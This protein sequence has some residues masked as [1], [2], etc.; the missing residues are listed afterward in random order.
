[1]DFLKLRRVRRDCDRVR[2]DRRR[3]F[4]C[5]HCDRECDRRQPERQVQQRFNAVEI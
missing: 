5:D 1:M 4:G 3:H 2:P